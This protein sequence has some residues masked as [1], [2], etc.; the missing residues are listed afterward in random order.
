MTQV[1]RYLPNRNR[2][3]I[4]KQCVT[5]HIVIHQKKRLTTSH[6]QRGDVGCLLRIIQFTKPINGINPEKSGEYGNK[7][8]RKISSTKYFNN[9][10]SYPKK[11]RRFI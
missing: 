4:G 3:A 8:V 1:F 2:Y 6:N 10:R 11:Q 5:T 9:Q 7:A